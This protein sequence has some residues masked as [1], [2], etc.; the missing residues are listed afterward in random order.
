M[1]S[2]KAGQLP[3]TTNNIAELQAVINALS[4]C[5]SGVPIELF[6]DSTYVADGSMKWLEGWKARGW[7]KGDKKPIKNKELWMKLD[8]L[9]TDKT[10][11]VI[12][13]SAHVG[14]EL[15]EIADGRARDAAEYDRGAGRGCGVA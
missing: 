7:R 12:H 1:Q 8:G 14:I 2:I 5:P 13:V 6:T 9:L 10:P 11:K 3:E 4:T 15:N